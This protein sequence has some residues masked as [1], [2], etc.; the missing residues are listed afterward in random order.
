MK[1]KIK[2]NKETFKRELNVASIFLLALAYAVGF[3][4]VLWFIRGVIK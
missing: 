4:L 1:R 3:N 2:F